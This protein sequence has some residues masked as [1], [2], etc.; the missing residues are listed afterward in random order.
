[1][2]AP[3]QREEEVRDATASR[4]GPL[5]VERSARARREDRA[6]RCAPAFTAA[7]C[8]KWRART[9]TDAPSSLRGHD[10]RRSDD[11]FVQTVPADHAGG[12]GC[13]EVAAIERIDV[14][15]KPFYYKHAETPPRTRILA[16]AL[17]RSSRVE[18]DD[19]SPPI[20]QCAGGE[21]PTHCR[22]RPACFHAH[23]GPFDVRITAL[24]GVARARAGSATF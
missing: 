18:R 8:Q 11:A 12:S 23:T 21:A 15:W 3:T 4:N 19:A 5:D 6:L 9:A 17:L 14:A 20:F 10:V 24:A 1:M 7:L 16:A 2:V 13:S 22:A